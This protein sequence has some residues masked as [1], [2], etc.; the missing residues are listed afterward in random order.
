[1]NP[2]LETIPLRGNRVVRGSADLMLYGVEYRFNSGP[3]VKPWTMMENMT[4]Q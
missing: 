1:M 3:I 4:T 2:T